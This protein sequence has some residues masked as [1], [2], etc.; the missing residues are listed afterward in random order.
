MRLELTHH[1]ISY[2]D[3]NGGKVA[4]EGESNKTK[5]K[6]ISPV[7]TLSLFHTNKQTKNNETDNKILC[8]MVHLKLTME[9]EQIYK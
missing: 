2:G 8:N 6:Y 1:N 4:V 9:I 7:Y 3:K 5:E